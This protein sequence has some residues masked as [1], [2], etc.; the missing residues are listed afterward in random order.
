MNL[1]LLLTC[2][3]RDQRPPRLPAHACGERPDAAVGHAGVHGRVPR[4]R[5]TGIGAAVRVRTNL[6]Q[7]ALGVADDAGT[8][9]AGILPRSFGSVRIGNLAA[10]TLGSFSFKAAIWPLKGAASGL[11]AVNVTSLFSMRSYV[12]PPFFIDTP[13]LAN[14]PL[15]CIVFEKRLFDIAVVPGSW[16][17]H[18]LLGSCRY[19]FFP[20]NSFSIFRPS[21]PDSFK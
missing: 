12:C 16:T 18:L 21:S 13:Y 9:R 7:A 17:A 2:A 11:F 19:T 1:P 3:R 10:N 8:D 4:R 5:Q 15:L 20:S 14:G 6:K